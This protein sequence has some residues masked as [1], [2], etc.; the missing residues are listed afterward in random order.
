[1]EETPLIEI[2][3]F[4]DPV[5]TWCWGSEPVLRKLETHYG[6]QLRIGY[7]M[8]GLV[9]DIR[10][11][12][13]NFNGI[14]GD[15][16]TS[17]T[18]IVKHWLE[19]SE[20]HGMPVKSE[21]FHLF[22]NE[23]PSTYPQNI[24]YKAAQMEDQT[25]ADRFLR[26]MR[27]ASAAEARQTSRLEVLIELAAEVGL[28]VAAFI[29]RMNDGSAEA[30]FEKDLQST[31]EFGAQGFPTFLV[32]YGEKGILL[33]GYQR[34][35]TFQAVIKTLAGES[36]REQA[37]EKSEENVLAFIEKQGRVA[38]VE[39]QTAFALTAD[40]QQQ[41]VDSLLSK[42]LISRTPAGNGL[43]IQRAANPMVCDPVTGLCAK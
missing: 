14:G 39:I 30:A 9:K 1:M 3:E 19:A 43:F 40:E 23:Y 36:I 26:R 35:A 2:I 33:R 20:R 4:T 25:L 7:V 16:E 29:E 41:M 27:E 28:D 6:D 38:P 34:Y 10:D 15:A 17:N 32:K 5:C 42:Q 8:G 12:Y 13:D 31:A 18:R 21:G 24:A 11:F 37:P 22:S